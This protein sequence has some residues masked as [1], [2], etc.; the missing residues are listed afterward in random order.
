MI[1]R[2]TAHDARLPWEMHLDGCSVKT[3]KLLREIMFNWIVCCAR[4]ELRLRTLVCPKDSVQQ[5]CSDVVVHVFVFLLCQQGVEPLL[6]VHVL[7]MGRREQLPVVAIQMRF[8]N[9]CKVDSP[10][11]ERISTQLGHLRP[12]VLGEV[13]CLFFD[14]LNPAHLCRGQPPWSIEI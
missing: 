3:T 10:C 9:R 11:D 12:A 4:R 6:L 1:R 14:N 13:S 2:S 5:S 7:V 8:L